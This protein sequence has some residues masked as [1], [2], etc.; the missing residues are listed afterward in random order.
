MPTGSA[1]SPVEARGARPI[2]PAAATPSAI[3]RSALSASRLAAY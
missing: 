2:L 3:T 1:E